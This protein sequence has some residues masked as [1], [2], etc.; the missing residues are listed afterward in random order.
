M[1]LTPTLL[2]N[3]ARTPVKPRVGVF[4]TPFSGRAWREY[5]YLCL[6][7]LLAPVALAYVVAVPSLAA[8]VAVTVV[9]L[10][11]VG[12]MIVAARGWGRLSRSMARALLGIDVAPPARFVRPNGFWP[13]LAAT[14]GD[15]AGWRALGFMLVS[16]PLAVLGFTA[17]T[18]LL[19]TGL[20]GLTHWLWSRWLPPQQAGDGTWHRGASFGVDWFADTP[21]R[22]LALA[23]AGLLL[24][25][26][27]PWVTRLFTWA[28]AFLTRALLGPTTSGQRVAELRA[29]RAGAVEDADARLRSIERDLHDGTQARLV[30]VAMQLGEAREFLEPGGDPAAAAQ[31]VRTA[32][33][34]T[35]EALA[36]L[37]EIARGIH[38]PA[39]DA[40]LAVALET[41]AARAQLPTLLDIDPGLDAEALTPAVASI[42]Y[43]SVA[44]LVTN[45]AKHAG[46]SAVSVVVGASTGQLRVQV[47]D[48]GHGGAVVVPPDGSG[49]RTGLAGLVERV[50]AVD[51]TFDLSSPAGGPTVATL[52]LPT[53]RTS[54]IPPARTRR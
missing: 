23:G 53:T 42:A 47:R 32:H 17:S 22:Q 24:L 45:A 10:L 25:L 46:A 49:R 43:F 31:M 26:V 28:F 12:G 18:T 40:G 51:G 35:K 41:L 4:V 11:L 33:E 38:P 36:E 3:P 7:L 52:T 13:T 29:S 50:R 6:Q 9:G 2:T 8:L 16:F 27:W 19:A 44:E 20:G 15:P 30:A 48:N 21:A 5:G 34:S 1:T 39:L 14:L 54:S 37:R